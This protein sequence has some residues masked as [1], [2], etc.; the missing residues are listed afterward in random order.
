MIYE[1]AELGPKL[2][3]PAPHF[4]LKN[5]EGGMSCLE[6]LLG[7]RGLLIGFVSDIWKPASI[8]RILYMQR[9]LAKF[10]SEGFN[11]ALIIGDKQ[12]NLWTF[13]MSSPLTVVVPMLADE[14][15][16]IHR[17]F[18]MNHP[19]LLLLNPDGLIQAKW[20]MPDEQVWPKAKELLQEVEVAASA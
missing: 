1:T 5:H 7:S 6:Q 10:E 18:S 11:L 19:G 14:D 12:Y 4:S 3:T 9:H 2:H 8:R 20:L 13:Y 16:S 15:M 17:A